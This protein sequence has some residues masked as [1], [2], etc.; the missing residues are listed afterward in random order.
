MRRLKNYYNEVVGK[1]MRF[2]LQ[3]EKTGTKPGFKDTSL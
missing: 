3:K 1:K 2:K